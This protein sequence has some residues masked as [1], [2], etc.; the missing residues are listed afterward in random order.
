MV[1]ATSCPTVTFVAGTLQRQ[2]GSNITGGQI[3]VIDG[4]YRTDATATTAVT[5]ATG[6]VDY[7]RKDGFRS[8]DRIGAGCDE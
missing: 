2:A 4:E 3:T 1:L 6:T 8:C 5:A 7:R